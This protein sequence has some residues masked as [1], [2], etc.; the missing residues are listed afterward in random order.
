MDRAHTR[1][2]K[3]G[4][5][6]T[7]NHSAGSYCPIKLSICART[8]ITIPSDSYSTIAARSARPEYHPSVLGE[9]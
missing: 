1:P 4:A 8:L 9:N 7:D 5:Q 2:S 6:W 3:A